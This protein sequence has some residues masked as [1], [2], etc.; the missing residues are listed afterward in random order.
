MSTPRNCDH[1]LPRDMCDICKPTPTTP[2]SVSLQLGALCDLIK[3]QLK[4][5]AMTALKNDV[6]TWQSIADALTLLNVHFIL[7][8]SAVVRGRQ[9]LIKM[10]ARGVVLRDRKMNE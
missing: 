8:H 7:P 3:T 4:A 10:V 2:L 1:G 6:A 5:Q 9:K